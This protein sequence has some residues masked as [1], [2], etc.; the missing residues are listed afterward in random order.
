MKKSDIGTYQEL[1]PNG[2][3][4]DSWTRKSGSWAFAFW[5]LTTIYFCASY[6]YHFYVLSKMVSITPEPAISQQTF[7]TLLNQLEVINWTIFGFF[8]LAVFA[9]KALQKFAE[10][11]AGIKSTIET[12]ST[13]TK[14]T[15]E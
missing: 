3:I 13:S 12:E 14:T 1:Q 2:M 8:G 4:A 9:P 6:E 7:I 10:T 11:K 15:T 5:V